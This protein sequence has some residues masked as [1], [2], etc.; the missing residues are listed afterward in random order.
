MSV[1]EHVYVSETSQMGC[2]QLCGNERKANILQHVSLPYLSSLKAAASGVC[3]LHYH[4]LLSAGANYPKLGT[5]LE[6]GILEPFITA[7][8]LH[9]NH[10]L[11]DN[12]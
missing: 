12:F 1:R 2:A 3:Q 10:L 8:R 5:E 9:W 6:K 11:A 7:T 4:L